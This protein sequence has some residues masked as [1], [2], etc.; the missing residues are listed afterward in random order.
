MK[1]ESIMIM[2]CFSV[3]GYTTPKSTRILAIFTEYGKYCRIVLKTNTGEQAIVKEL[4][5][6]TIAPYYRVLFE[7]N[8]EEEATNFQYTIAA[9]DETSDFQ[10]N[11][12]MLQ[13]GDPKHVCIPDSKRTPKVGLVS[14]ND[15]LDTDL[16]DQQLTILWK[17]LAERVKNKDV[18]VV[19]HSGDQIYADK[20]PPHFEGVQQWSLH[21][22]RKHYV[23]TWKKEHVADVLG[24]VPNMFMWDDHEISDGYGSQNDDNTTFS[25][26]RFGVA[27]QV[28]QEMQA[29]LNP[30]SFDPNS[31]AWSMTIGQTGFVALDGRSHRSWSN[32]SVLG[33]QQ[34]QEL[35]HA[36]QKMSDTNNIIYLYVV[37]AVP[38]IHLSP[39]VIDVTLFMANLFAKSEVDDIRDAWVAPNNRR[40]CEQVIDIIAK[41]CYPMKVKA[42][43]LSGDVHVGS[44]GYIQSTR[45][46][47]TGVEISH[48]TS[49]GITHSPPGGALG[50]LYKHIANGRA[51]IGHSDFQGQLYN[52]AKQGTI[53]FNRNYAIVRMFFDYDEQGT[54]SDYTSVKFFVDD[55]GTVRVLKT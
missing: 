36:L 55:E 19:I 9:A 29:C 15:I 33:P 13:N 40:E 18:D 32:E 27:K 28:F 44:Y 31:F 51:E 20:V 14:C 3:V 48:V 52:I 2:P 35:S 39:T 21:W 38:F 16:P 10:A 7:M 47:S 4:P 30:P 5:C 26:N 53:I 43:I 54:F 1:K 34:I 46:D 49:S 50:A 37:S 41:F 42:T 25:K 8:W 24:S 45:R 6:E 12:I 23:E 17:D 22:Y 11:D